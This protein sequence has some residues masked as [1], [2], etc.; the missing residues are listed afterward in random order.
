MR[1][2]LATGVILLMLSV[3]VG[4]VS[5][6]P[7]ER[8][9]SLNIHYINGDWSYD[10]VTITIPAS[11]DNE[12]VYALNALISG[13]NLP[14][15]SFNELP[16]TLQVNDVTLT[17]GVATVDLPGNFNSI[18]NDAGYA[19]DVV[20]D[21]LIYNV[22]KF[23]DI[24]EV[25]FTFDGQPDDT[26]KFSRL[27]RTE[28]FSPV[29][30]AKEHKALPYQLTEKLHKVKDSFKN[31]TKEQQES[32]LDDANQQD[33][34][35]AS[36][37]Q[38]LAAYNP[39]VTT[40]VVDPGHGGSDPGAV[41]QLGSTTYSEK[42]INLSMALHLKNYLQTNGYT[43]LMTRTTD[44]AVGINDRYAFANNNNADLFISVHNNSASNSSAKGATALYPNNHDVAQSKDVAY[45][46]HHF[47]TNDMSQYAKPYP[48]SDSDVK[49]V[50]KWTTM[51]AVIT[52]TAF[53][54]NTS[55]L[56]YLSSDFNRQTLAEDLGVGIRYWDQYGEY[57]YY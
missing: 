2:M 46:M 39:S 6:Q 29:V 13:E 27:T 20:M 14:E 47:V 50:L 18:V 45:W 15:Y 44:V 7:V 10:P 5:A 1:K 40:I 16:P 3:Q 17:Q 22:F 38:V 36:Q 33:L 26:F 43:V 34:F 42:T 21:I 48:M 30:E 41:G 12:Y 57:W 37:L 11:E 55:D 9:D 31:M 28:Y 54:S 51:P 52:E 4:A 19:A 56:T 25:N 53:M 8:V 49:G 24:S 35:T 32:F 23:G